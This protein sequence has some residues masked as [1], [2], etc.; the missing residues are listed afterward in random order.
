ML[1]KSGCDFHITY[2]GEHVNISPYKLIIS[3]GGD[4]TF[5]EAAGMLPS[6]KP[7]LGINSAPGY[8]VGRFCHPYKTIL[9][10]QLFSIIKDASRY[11][12]L[13]RIRC[14]IDKAPP[15]DALNDILISHT[16]PACLCRYLITIGSRNEEHLNSGLWVSSAPGSTAAIFSAGGQPLGLFEKKFQYL[17]RELYPRTGLRYSLTGGVLSSRSTIVVVP[18]MR[19]GEVFVDG[20]NRSHPCHFGSSI[21]ISVSPSPVTV[22]HP[23]PHG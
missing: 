5:L 19:E 18:L 4:G 3:V 20:P 6:G 12:L 8:S 11:R 21:R 1:A 13:H 22:I 9:S 15:F 7:L 2:R 17:P 16:N 14:R 10:E 23:H